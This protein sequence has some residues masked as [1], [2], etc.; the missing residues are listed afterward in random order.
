MLGKNVSVEPFDK[1]KALTVF[2][3]FN[4]QVLY[5]TIEDLS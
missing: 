2:P 4:Q 1:R 5:V 3:A